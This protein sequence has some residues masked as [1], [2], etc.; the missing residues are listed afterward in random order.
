MRKILI[1]FMLFFCCVARAQEQ[2]PAALEGGSEVIVDDIESVGDGG[3]GV[4]NSPILRKTTLDKLIDKEWIV[5]SANG[6]VSKR[7]DKREKTKFVI[8]DGVCD[9]VR[10]PYYLSYTADTRFESDKIGTSSFGD[11]IVLKAGGGTIIYKIINISEIE[12]TLQ[13][14][15]FNRVIRGSKTVK[16]RVKRDI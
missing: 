11:F 10:T 12:L 13:N 14:V 4:V 1:L 2:L 16:H 5:E 15:T 7:F 3:V 9:T 8:F 6:N